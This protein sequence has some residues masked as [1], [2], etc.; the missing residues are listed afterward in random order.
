[1]V[2]DECLAVL[3]KTRLEQNVAGRPYVPTTVGRGELP[4]LPWMERD[5][6]MRDEDDE[7]DCSLVLASVEKSTRA[8]YNTAI[9]KYRQWARE[10]ALDPDALNTDTL[11]WYIR[12]LDEAKTT[13]CT[14]R[15]IRPA[16]ELY[17]SIK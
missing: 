6:N 9:K 8:S 3:S 16:L 7:Y 1:M 10:K 2:P 12:H 15:T 11:S 17:R 4:T 5:L 14:L 13:Y